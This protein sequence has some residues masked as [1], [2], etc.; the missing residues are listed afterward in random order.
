MVNLTRFGGLWMLIYCCNST[1]W[2]EVIFVCKMQIINLFK[3][4]DI[5]IYKNS[6]WLITKRFW[7]N[8][9]LT[10]SHCCSGSN[11][12]IMWTSR[13][14]FKQVHSNLNADFVRKT[15][16]IALVVSIRKS[17]NHFSKSQFSFIR[18]PYSH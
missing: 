14:F 15:K 8:F 18:K 13:S 9:N 16:F 6:V 12:R 11:I 2:L 10:A 3:S 4:K 5:T 7:R 17:I 1:P